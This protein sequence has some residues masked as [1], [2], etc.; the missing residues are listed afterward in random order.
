M[1]C[2]Y[3]SLKE[4]PPTCR[5]SKTICSMTQCGRAA[6]SLLLPT[7]SVLSLVCVCTVCRE[8]EE[9]QTDGAYTLLPRH[10]SCAGHHAGFPPFPWAV[11]CHRKAQ[12][13]PCLLSYRMSTLKDLLKCTPFLDPPWP[14]P[15][16]TPPCLVHLRRGDSQGPGSRLSQVSDARCGPHGQVALC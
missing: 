10:G 14:A 12:G 16:S 8:T 1:V 6:R 2:L 4:G 5:K 9:G 15:S 7:A 3:L 11:C 13:L